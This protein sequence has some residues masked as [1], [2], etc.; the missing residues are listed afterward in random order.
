[1]A[2]H[3]SGDYWNSFGIRWGKRNSSTKLRPGT[4]NRGA[5]RIRSP[6]HT[7]S[8]PFGIE[9]HNPRTLKTKSPSAAARRPILLAVDD[10][11]GM[12]LLVQ[13]VLA[14]FDCAIVEATNGYNALFAMERAMPDLILLDVNM[15]IMGGLEM[16]TLMRSNPTLKAVPVIMLTSPAD[17]SIMAQL[18]ALGTHGHL[19]K[20]IAPDALLEKVRSV[21]VLSPAKPAVEPPV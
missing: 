10:A 1:M 21:I 12:R 8:L 4:P 16:L 15:P 5:L 7:E 17:R 20:P 18:A 19:M 2:K 6:V 14:P 13:R 9:A 3:D 11:K